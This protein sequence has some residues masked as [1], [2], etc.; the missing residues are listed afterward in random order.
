MQSRLASKVT[1]Q[2]KS[3]TM[4]RYAGELAADTGLWRR[5]ASAQSMQPI[6]QLS[7]TP[8]SKKLRTSLTWILSYEGDNF[9]LNQQVC[10]AG[11]K[12]FSSYAKDANGFR[13]QA[14]PS[15]NYLL[16]L[17]SHSVNLDT[18]SLE[19]LSSALSRRAALAVKGL[20]ME[21]S[22]TKVWTDL[23]WRCAS[24]ARAITE[25]FIGERLL[26]ALSNK[27][28]GIL[29]GLGKEESQAIE[30]VCALVRY[31]T[32]FPQRVRLTRFWQWLLTTLVAASADLVEFSV[33]KPGQLAELRKAEDDA[34]KRVLPHSIALT[35]AFAFSDFE[36][37]SSLG[38]ADGRAYEDLFRRANE[39]K[40]LNLGKEE[41]KKDIQVILKL[42]SAGKP[43]L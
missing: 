6:Y 30:E 23:S 15:T 42:A 13:R 11:I 20:A 17:E 9:I 10:R 43:K 36:L 32:F 40:D 41:Y 5:P 14:A 27:Q 2:P 37:N 31:F 19:S 1:F 4:S 8:L 12:A 18:S 3:L 26:A 16:S 35:D 7:R 24:V 21:A 28:D 34:A 39:T 25:A 22:K 38:R 29:A 33:L